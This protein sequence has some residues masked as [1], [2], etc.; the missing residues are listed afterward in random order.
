MHRRE[1][2]PPLHFYLRCSSSLLSFIKKRSASQLRATR[3]LVNNDSQNV[4]KSPPHFFSFQENEGRKTI[5]PYFSRFLET[6]YS[7]YY[8][9]LGDFLIYGIPA[10][11]H[12]LILLLL[13][14]SWIFSTDFIYELSTRTYILNWFHLLLFSLIF[15]ILT[16]VFTLQLCPICNMY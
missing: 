4:L 5:F 13:L 1:W 11:I 10:R 9:E 8:T 12:P 6:L 15:F 14:F 16:L 7:R 3:I 2:F